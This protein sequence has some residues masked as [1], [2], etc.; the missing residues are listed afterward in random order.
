M[1]DIADM[2]LEGILDEQTGE[3]IDDELS[4]QG[5]PGYPRTLGDT[6]MKYNHRYPK[7]GIVM[8]LSRNFP[9]IERKDYN[10][11][12]FRYIQ[13]HI[14]IDE[15]NRGNRSWTFLAHKI[16]QSW[17]KFVAYCKENQ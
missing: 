4:R 6:G 13:A 5:G 2:I 7:R 17:H 15:L 8:Y 1:G 14:D 3:F 11:F 10:E 16:Q 9:A 12:C